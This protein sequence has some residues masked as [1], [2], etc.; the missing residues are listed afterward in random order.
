MASSSTIALPT[1]IDFTAR[2][3]DSIK[4]AL[5]QYL[6]DNFSSDF[7]DI[8]ESQLGIAILE[9][10]AYIGASQAFYLD[11]AANEA[12]LATARQRRNIVLLA[13]NVG[14]QPYLASAASVDMVVDTSTMGVSTGD[15]FAVARGQKLTSTGGQIFEVVEDQ[16][17]IC[18]D[19]P[20][21]QFSVNSGLPST[22]LAIS[23]SQG[24]SKTFTTRSNGQP[25]QTFKLDQF[26]VIDGSIRGYVGGTSTDSSA[27][28]WTGVNALQLG[29]PTDIDNQSIFQVQID[30]NDKATIKFGDNITGAVPSNDTTVSFDYR[31]GGGAAGNIAANTLSGSLNAVKNL[32][33]AVTFNVVNPSPAT[34]GQDRE[35]SSSIKFFAPL[36]VK[37]NDRAIT[38]NDY[39]TLSNGFSDGVT[40][41]IAKAAALA[42]P[43]DGLANV[44]TVYVWTKTSANTLSASVPQALKDA[45][46][47][48]LDA[49]RV[50]TVYVQVMNGTN[51]PVDINCLLQIDTRYVRQDVL[52]AVNA[53][54]ASIFVE[55]RVRYGNELRISWIYDEIMSV[56]GVRW[57]QVTSPQ[58]DINVGVVREL[59]SGTLP[60]QTGVLINETKLP[61][62]F[63]PGSA[64]GTAIVSSD[65]YYANYR[66][67]ILTGPAAGQTRKILSYD[68]PA[69]EITVDPSWDIPAPVAGATF[70]LWHP[71]RVGLAT[72]ESGVNNFF[73]H[74]VIGITNGV[75]N[76]QNRVVRSYDGTTKVVSTDKNWTTAPT[77]SSS[78]TVFADLKCGQNESLVLGST[79][80][81]VI[82]S[83]DES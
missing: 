65:G 29:D 60:D 63:D 40:G 20:T 56:P 41:S 64:L 67:E 47:K 70:R 75:G 18:T 42:D 12:Y 9:L 13:R 10:F 44:V 30:E 8:T 28:Q 52:D 23:M 76:G 59:I 57:C 4:V 36:W 62:T 3:F 79:S 74:R 6:K 16:N 1:P 50:V 43:T 24:E 53:K 72:T 80:L 11:R 14:Y 68:G 81:T 46:Q 71:R 54:V 17:I 48:Y 78:Y 2:E 5:T 33:T 19:G 32:L 26:P 38:E 27:V 55:D 45:L 21:K 31:V 61:L 22:T 37:T 82:S 39:F 69:H 35:T 58:I 77:L 51:I 25:F 66:I 15:A 73:L 49:R 34:G 83:L 7:S